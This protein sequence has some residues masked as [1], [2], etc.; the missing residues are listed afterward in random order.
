MAAADLDPG[1]ALADLRALRELTEDERG[2]QRVAWTETWAKA[3]AWLRERLGELPLEVDVDEA[4]NLWAVLQ[5]ARAETVVIGSHV[6]S[7]P[8]GGWLDGALGVLGGLEVLRAIAAREERPPV[9][10]A[11]V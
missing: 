10:L 2:A 1:R 8:D 5:G 3:R 11:L 6:D 4:G 7:V 9:T